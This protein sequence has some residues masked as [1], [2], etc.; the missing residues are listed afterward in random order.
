MTHHTFWFPLIG[1]GLL[2]VAGCPSSSS[3]PAASSEDAGGGE[4]DT[5]TPDTTATPDTMAPLPD[6]TPDSEGIDTGPV[7]GPDMIEVQVTL[8]GEPAVDTLLVQGGTTHQWRTDAAGRARI[9]VDRSVEGEL[10]VMASHPEARQRGVDADFEA[11]EPQRIE[12]FRYSGDNP[13]YTFQDP[14]E[15]SRRGSTSQCGHCHQTI[16]DAWYL[17]PHRTSASNPTVHDLYAGVA[18]AIDSEEACVE[19]GGRWQ[20]GLQ[21]GTDKPGMRCYLG[22]GLLPMLNSDC[23]GDQQPSCDTEATHFGGC[24]SC[25]APAIDGALQGR[26]L[27]EARGVAYDYGVSCDVCHRVDRVDLDDLEPGVAGRLHLTRPGERSP[28]LALGVFLPLTFGPSHDS[29]NPRMGS[30][31]RDHFRNGHICAGCHQHDQPGEL[32]AL[33]PE[34]WPEGRLPVQSTWEEWR[35]GPLSEA[36]PCPS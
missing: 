24:A 34:R 25:H 23:G 19:R 28:S 14:G 18:S 11:D 17:S 32:A 4:I 30:V 7:L 6:T 36:A 29:P 10:I 2:L 9:T 13:N 3:S 22:V 33:D 12:L 20:E 35:Q 5:E 26:D 31:Q 1:W 16:N 15:P 27:L 8:D 21:P